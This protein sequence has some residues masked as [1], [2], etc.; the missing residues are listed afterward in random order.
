MLELDGDPKV[1]IFFCAGR[2]PNNGISNGLQGE[3]INIENEC[4]L[5]FVEFADAMFGLSQRRPST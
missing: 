5:V 1:T 2:F 4:L 3:S